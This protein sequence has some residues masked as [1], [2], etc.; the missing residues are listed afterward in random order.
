M[1]VKKC[2]RKSPFQ[3]E[4]LCSLC[5]PFLPWKP[6]QILNKICPEIGDEASSTSFFLLDGEE[7]LQTDPDRD[8]GETSIELTFVACACVCKQRL[9]H[10]PKSFLIA[11]LRTIKEGY[12]RD[13]EH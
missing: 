2:C 13:F 4:G 7:T 5:F 10:E 12:L 9:R 3:I 8:G 1:A 6:N 11:R